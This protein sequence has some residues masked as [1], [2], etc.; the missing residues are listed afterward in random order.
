MTILSLS[1]RIKEMGYGIRKDTAYLRLYD[2]PCCK[3][4]SK[5]RTHL[6]GKHHVFVNFWSCCWFCN[7]CF[8]LAECLF[9]PSFK[10]TFW[11]KSVHQKRSQFGQIDKKA[12]KLPENPKCK[13]IRDG[14]LMMVLKKMKRTLL[15]K[16]ERRRNRGWNKRKKI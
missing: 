10:W 5:V 9:V 3:S 2:K 11:N 1:D 7:F 6:G 12:E 4:T 13:D 16:L 14:T 8:G 15:K